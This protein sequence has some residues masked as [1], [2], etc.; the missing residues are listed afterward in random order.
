MLPL[1]LLDKII[2][3][4]NPAICGKIKLTHIIHFDDPFFPV[5]RYHVPFSP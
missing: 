3:G 4:V 2:N 5:F 1:T